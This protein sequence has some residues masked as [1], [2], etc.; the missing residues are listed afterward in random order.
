MSDTLATLSRR[1]RTGE[2]LLSGWSGIAEPALADIMVR[3]GFDTVVL[4]MQHGAYTVE[5]ALRAIA[6]MAL[7]G[8]PA[9]VRIPIGDNATA[10]RML[11]GGAAAIIAPMVNSVEDARSFAAAVKY[12]PMGERSWGPHRALALSGL[13][14]VAYLAAANDMHLAI[15]MIETGVALDA[16]DAILAEPGVDGVFVGPSDLS[17]S[18][19]GGTLDPH[20]GPVQKA[21]DH[22]A[23]RVRAAGKFAGLFCFDGPQ[24]KAMAARGF[25]LCSIATDSLL[26]AGAA[27]AA[28]AGAR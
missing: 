21:L 11:D 9:I 16:L 22:V 15:P 28:I 8:A 14:P 10:S 3:Q 19:S 7:A 17:I 26:L 18:L 5:S 4:D 1:L 13:D 6:A 23:A 12:R 24:A 2:N 20:G 27:R 25:A